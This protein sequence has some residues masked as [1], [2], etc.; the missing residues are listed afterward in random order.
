MELEEEKT[1][2]PQASTNL[3]PIAFGPLS[4]LSLTPL[5]P[6]TSLKPKVSLHEMFNDTRSCYMF[7]SERES[8]IDKPFELVHV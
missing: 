1:N 2:S 8:S 7:M 3:F 5:H 6:T 4:T